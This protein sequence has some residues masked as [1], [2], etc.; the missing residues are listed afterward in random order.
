MSASTI[1]L[2]HGA[3]HGA[4]CFGM[5]Q[6]ELERQGV[7]ARAVDL[8]SHGDP[9]EQLGGL[10]DDVAV[11]RDAIADTDGEVILLGHSYGGV[12]I[13][14]AADDQPNVSKLMY[15]AAFLP[16]EGDSMLSLT[17]GGR[18]PWLE[19]D[20]RTHSV[21]RG[22]GARLF[23]SEAPAA[24]AKWAEAQL[25]AQSLSSFTDQVGFAGWRHIDST[26]LICTRD[27]SLPP[28]MQR[29]MAQQTKR[30]V[31]L[32]SDHSPFLSQPAALAGVLAAEL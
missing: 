22:W 18:A 7:H 5:L 15:L 11:V 6:R 14:Q 13:T 28:A 19:F 17:G 12:V 21:A 20:E 30:S 9:A 25:Q 26:Y 3:W 31:E 1:I 27:Q 23:Y 32:G 2:V 16:E 24:T 8:T 29:R 4:W 10:A